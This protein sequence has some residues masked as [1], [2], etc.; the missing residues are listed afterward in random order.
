MRDDRKHGIHKK[1]KSHREAT[2]WLF[3]YCYA[4]TKRGWLLLYVP[5][6]PFANIVPY[7]TCHNRHNE[8]YY[9][10][11]GIHLLSVARL[12]I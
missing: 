1:T 11:H 10:K 4:S 12:E 9:E 8:R 3:L 6:Q 5:V 7:Y 2:L